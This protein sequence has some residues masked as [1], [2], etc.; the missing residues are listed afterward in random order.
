MALVN[1]TTDTLKKSRL[2]E[3]TNRAWFNRLVQHPARKWSGSILTTPEPAWGWEREKSLPYL[4]TTPVQW[5]GVAVNELHPSATQSDPLHV[6]TQ[7]ISHRGCPAA[8][9]AATHA[10]LFTTDLISNRVATSLGEKNSRTY[11]FKTYFSDVLLR[12]G[13]IKSNRINFVLLTVVTT[14]QWC[15]AR[16]LHGTLNSI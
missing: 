10:T 6:P 4:T 15:D 16:L 12:C 14:Q 7:Q 5:R 13:H 1:S 8:R 11:V 9:T 2:R 3:R